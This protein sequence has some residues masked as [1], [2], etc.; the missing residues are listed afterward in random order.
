MILGMNFFLAEKFLY[1]HF[2]KK[3]NHVHLSNMFRESFLCWVHRQLLGIQR[4]NRKQNMPVSI[5]N[6]DGEMDASIKIF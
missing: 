2:V 4:L 1:Y 5:H 3:T 6:L